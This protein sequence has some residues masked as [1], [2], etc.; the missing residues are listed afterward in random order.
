MV[1]G[2][3]AGD[4]PRLPGS[5]AASMGREDP[6][7]AL[8][9]GVRDAGKSGRGP[10]LGD[11][12]WGRRGRL[13]DRNPRRQWRRR[14]ASQRPTGVAGPRS[15]WER[16]RACVSV[17]GSAPRALGKRPLPTPTSATRRVPAPPSGLLERYTLMHP[18]SFFFKTL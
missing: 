2:W 8:T 6:A 10:E 9:L 13:L 7:L 17:T 11:S 1:A 3:P 14:R 12:G 4:R 15:S 16:T 5:P 18:N